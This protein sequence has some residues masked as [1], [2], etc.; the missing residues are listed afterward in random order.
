LD[1]KYFFFQQQQKRKMKKEKTKQKIK[2]NKRKKNNNK[3]KIY[4]V[5][6]GFSQNYNEETIQVFAILRLPVNEKGKSQLMTKLP[7]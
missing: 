4:M 7:D 6:Q 5:N 3:N 2:K 1:G